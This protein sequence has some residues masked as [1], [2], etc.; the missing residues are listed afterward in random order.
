MARGRPSPRGGGSAGR[1]FGSDFLRRMGRADA[2]RIRAADALFRSK[3]RLE[4][5]SRR[6]GAVEAAPPRGGGG[7]VLLRL[8]PER[9]DVVRA[10]GFENRQERE[11][12]RRRPQAG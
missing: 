9:G 5:Q 1:G 11:E 12:D 6:W 2:R 8:F 10:R 7:E 4:A 3:R